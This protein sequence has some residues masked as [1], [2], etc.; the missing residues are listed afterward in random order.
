[1]LQFH[2]KKFWP[3]LPQSWIKQYNE[4]FFRFRIAE[5]IRKSKEDFAR[6][7]PYLISDIL[8]SFQ[9]VSL[10][11]QVKSNLTFA[12]HKLLD[13]SDKHSKELLSSN[14]E[15][16]AKEVFKS[17]LENYNQYYKYGGRV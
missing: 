17:V 7:A 4:I 3:D 8:A 15:G 11:P 2:R 6:V 5:K 16:A 13:I 9:R 14:L 12:L 1:M 10:Y